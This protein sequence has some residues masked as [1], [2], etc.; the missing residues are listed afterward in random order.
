MITFNYNTKVYYKDIDQMGV[1]YYN[2]YFEYFEQARTEL[3]ADIGL[4]VSEIE[5]KGFYLPVVSAK[6]NYKKGA[7]F[8]DEI[9]VK[10]KINEPPLAR[11]KIEYEVRRKKNN[12]FLAN[13]YTIHGFINKK[14]EPKR[15]PKFLLDTISPFF[16]SD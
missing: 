6:C 16:I 1:V 8:E 7:H 12:D 14:G 3:L 11:L 2:R 9:I 4:V 5:R 13:G 10:T 15:P